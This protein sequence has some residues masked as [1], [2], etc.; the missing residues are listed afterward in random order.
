MTG[1][2][3]YYESTVIWLHHPQGEREVIIDICSFEVAFR[4]AASGLWNMFQCFVILGPKLGGARLLELRDQLDRD[5]VPSAFHRRR[6]H[7]PIGLSI[8]YVGQNVSDLELVS[9]YPP[10]TIELAVLE[11]SLLRRLL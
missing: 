1:R 9:K 7:L 10:N 2:S 8:L 4:P 3:R 5:D 11:Y 6:N